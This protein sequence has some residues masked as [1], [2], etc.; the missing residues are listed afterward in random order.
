LK[1]RHCVKKF[2]LALCLKQNLV[3]A[4]QTE[5]R[6]RIAVICADRSEQQQKTQSNQCC[7]TY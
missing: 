6:S 4:L 3:Q 7:M 1:H 5:A 2:E